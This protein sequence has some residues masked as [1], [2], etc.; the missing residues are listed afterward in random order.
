MGLPKPEGMERKKEPRTEGSDWE[1]SIIL[2]TLQVVSMVTQ[3]PSRSS[4]ATAFHL[5]GI[6]LLRGRGHRPILGGLLLSLVTQRGP[7]ASISF[8]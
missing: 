2:P 7:R 4:D 5:C 6:H 1:A 3:G 8:S